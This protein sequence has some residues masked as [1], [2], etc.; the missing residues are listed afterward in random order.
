[1]QTKD[2]MKRIL[3]ALSFLAL[4]A[5]LGGCAQAPTKRP[6]APE[7]PAATVQPPATTGQQNQPIMSKSE[8]AGDHLAA[9]REYSQL[10]AQSQPPLRDYYHLRMAENLLRGGYYEPAK[11][12]L[13]EMDVS[14]MSADD[15]VSRHLL[16]AHLYQQQRQPKQMLDELSP[17]GR[18]VS[19]ALHRQ[20]YE[21][22][23]AAFKMLGNQLE[24]AK[25]LMQ[26]EPY[27]GKDEVADNHQKIWNALSLI[28]NQLLMQLRV[29]PPPNL[30]SG[31]LELAH[32]SKAYLDRPLEMKSHLENWKQLY[33]H[34]PALEDLYT[35]LLNRKVEAPI[36]THQVAVLLPLTGRYASAGTAIR[37]GL[38]AAYY[39][40][41]KNGKPQQ[42]LR[43]YDTAQGE[44]ITKLYDQAVADGCS[45]VIGPLQKNEVRDLIDQGGFPVPTVALNYS[46]EPVNE[47]NLFQYSL[48]PEDEVSQVAE[49][50]W[51]DGYNSVAVI[52]PKGAWGDRLLKAFQSKWDEFRNVESDDYRYDADKE[53]IAESIQKVLSIN[54]SRQRYHDLR[55]ILGRGIKYSE[56][57]RKDVDVIFVAGVNNKDAAQIRPQLKFFGAD[58]IPVYSTSHIYNLSMNK[59]M[60]RD[61]DGIL[62]CDMPWMLG[63]SPQTQVLRSRLDK[64]FSI[65]TS[66]NIRLF[67]FGIDAY[68]VLPMLRSL[69]AS[70]YE[71]YEGATGYLHVDK[72]KRILRK[73]D[74]AYFDHGEVKPINSISNNDT[75]G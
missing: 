9:A 23:A 59:R 12:A 39:Q 54:T 71:R 31:W 45:V 19:R 7:I 53:G 57:R 25:E 20:V 1:M 67:A 28:N 48:L 5:Y 70:P 63:T 69:Q 16:L 55:R 38:L 17:P 22:R 36:K 74:W 41:G 50:I 29:E 14:H 33:P 49:R 46:D 68:N 27:L 52:S 40:A 72:Y 26:V 61:M 51:Q 37:E 30:L 24:Y 35:T 11:R 42:Q 65:D 2:I 62:F 58:D 75:Q 4:L 66:P 10:A 56:R 64:D 8:E 15:R 34:H 44:D 60:V 21:L 32:I 13:M 43:F 18:Q 47:T 6:G 3:I 73:L